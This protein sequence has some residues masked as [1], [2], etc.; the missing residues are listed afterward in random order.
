LNLSERTDLIV[1]AVC[2]II[3]CISFKHKDKSKDNSISQKLL[4][5]F[6]REYPIFVMFFIGYFIFNYIFHTSKLKSFEGKVVLSLMWEQWNAV[7]N[8][9]IQLTKLIIKSIFKESILKVL[10]IG[11]LATKIL[12][13]E[14]IFEKLKF[15]ILQIREINFKDFSIKT[16]EAIKEQQAKDKEIEEIKK[17]EKSGSIRPEEAQSRIKDTEAEKEIIALLIDNDRIV[18]YIDNFINK[19]SNNIRIPINIVPKKINLT[20]IDKLFIYEIGPT[21]VKLMGIKPEK[22]EIVKE[23][24]NELLMKGII[25]CEN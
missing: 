21:S 20:A 25:Y 4:F 10:I 6:K 17:E 5:I 7:I 19:K 2:I 22:L 23:V 16:Q 9:G 14:N 24:F 8:W 3:V 12:I 18:K 11:Y 1:L 15:F 13:N